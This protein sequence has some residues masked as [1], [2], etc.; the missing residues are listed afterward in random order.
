[1]KVLYPPD[2]SGVPS[3]GRLSRCLLGSFTKPQKTKNY[4]VINLFVLFYH[5]DTFFSSSSFGDAE[6]SSSQ[7]S[8]LLCGAFTDKGT[9]VDLG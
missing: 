5:E 9:S 8:E 3:D 2:L 4:R 1:M 6:L 7:S